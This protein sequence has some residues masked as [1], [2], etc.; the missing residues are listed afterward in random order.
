MLASGKIKNYQLV[1]GGLSLLAFPATLLFFKMGLGPEWGYLSIIIFSIVCFIARL[2]FIKKML[3]GFFVHMLLKKALIPIFFS[4]ISVVVIAYFIN[5]SIQNSSFVVFVLKVALI[6]F[7]CC[8]VVF[9]IG[10]SKEE[11]SKV[12]EIVKNKIVKKK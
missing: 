9:F 1:V 7:S 5:L 4:T 10:F 11:K 12:L 3:P 2:P 8:I 6:V